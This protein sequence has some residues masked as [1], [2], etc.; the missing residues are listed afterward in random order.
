MYLKAVRLAGIIYQAEVKLAA[1]KLLLSS[2][3]G[4]LM[5]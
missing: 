3:G 4:G 1:G 5:V 2:S